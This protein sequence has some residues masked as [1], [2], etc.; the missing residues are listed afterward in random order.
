MKKWIR[1]GLCLGVLTAALT[2]SALAATPDYTTDSAGT[3]TYAEGKYTA[4]YAN[5][6]S[7]NQYVILVVKGSADDY[8]IS[9]NTIMY[10]DQKA[11]E[12]E[13]I[14]FDFIPKSTPD[15]VV[16]LGGEFSDGQSP[17]VLGALIGQGVEI[18]GTV[19]IGVSVTSN[20]TLTVY[21]PDGTSAGSSTMSSD[22]SYAI[23]SIPEGTYYIKAS[24]P[25]FV[26]N[27]VEVIV[28]GEENVGEI[29]VM[30]YGGDVNT[31]KMINAADLLALLSDFG[32]TEQDSITNGYADINEDTAVNAADLL[33]LLANYGNVDATLPVTE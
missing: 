8:S 32:K 3:V 10:I 29:S 19:D 9:E 16:L 17:K 4:S 2:C 31:D 24:K 22:G 5:A 1:L 28:T 21:H 14:S 20:V 33:E 7:G 6:T 25:G 13:T 23:S 12:S 15:C 30:L 27:M 11:A 18:S 26:S